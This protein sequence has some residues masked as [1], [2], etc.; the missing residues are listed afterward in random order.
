MSRGV[1]DDRRGMEGPLY[2][3]F[4]P[5]VMSGISQDVSEFLVQTFLHLK[6]CSQSTGHDRRPPA[7]P[8]QLGGD[9]LAACRHAASVLAAAVS[10][11]CRC[12][13]VTNRGGPKSD[14]SGQTR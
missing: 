5:T 1:R 10:R 12:M 3:L 14:V 6:L 7:V 11:A 13:P 9:M 8:P 4:T 2:P